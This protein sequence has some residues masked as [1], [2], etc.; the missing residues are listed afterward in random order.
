MK[1]PQ[2]GNMNA[3]EKHEERISIPASVLL[4]DEGIPP[5]NGITIG[6]RMRALAIAKA[7][8]VLTSKKNVEPKKPAA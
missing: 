5:P 8:R 4:L 1:N 6:E 2:Y 7:Q 3:T